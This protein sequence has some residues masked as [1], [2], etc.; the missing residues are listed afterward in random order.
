ILEDSP[1]PQPNNTQ[2]TGNP[3]QGIPRLPLL[4]ALDAN[5]DG[6]LDKDELS[7]ATKALMTLD[8]N[9]DGKLTADEY[10]GA[11]PTGGRQGPPGATP[12]DA[13]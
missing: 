7:A 9:H 2:P 3:G 13:R 8:K 10:R 12:P 11:V 5:K 1:S 6:T 4:G